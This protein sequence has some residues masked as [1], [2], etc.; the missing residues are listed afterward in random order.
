MSERTYTEEQLEEAK[1]YLRDRLRNEQ[2]MSAD[3]LHL[4]VLY[5]SYLLDAL[6]GNYSDYDVEMLIADLVEQLLADVELLAVDEHDRDDEI[7]AFINREIGGNDLKERI[8]ERCHTFLDEIATVYL[9]GK[10][11][12][13]NKQ[14]MLSSIKGSLKNPWDNPIL[15]AARTEK[16]RGTTAFPDSLDLEPRSYG[17]GVAV[18]SLSALDLITTHAIAEGWNEYLHLEAKDGGAVG[19]FVV[20]G[21]SYPCDEC[22]EAASFFHPIDDLNYLPCLHPHCVCCAVYVYNERYA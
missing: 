17:Q 10:L 13:H 14:T 11:L 9:T 3:V 21:S 7:L 22:D 4:L 8:N 2:S 6:F 18:S 19:Y 5:A 1:E 15:I 16:E 20:R 12:G